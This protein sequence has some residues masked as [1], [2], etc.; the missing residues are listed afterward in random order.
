MDNK[1][2]TLQIR[3]LRCM[4]VSSSPVNDGDRDP[5]VETRASKW[6]AAPDQHH[7]LAFP[8]LFAAVGRRGR[9]EGVLWLQTLGL[10]L[11]V[12]GAPFAFLPEVSGLQRF[13]PH[14]EETD[15]KTGWCLSIYHDP[16]EKSCLTPHQPP[17]TGSESQ[18]QV[19]TRLMQRKSIPS[20]L[21]IYICMLHVRHT[22]SF[23][24]K[25]FYVFI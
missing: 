13:A 18:I 3:E 6:P 4:G 20:D 22:V 24:K 21:Q 12:A 14:A 19:R 25:R 5:D 1:E 8:C 17:P 2:A 9:D 7:L 10:T 11:H 23:F 16:M 15:L